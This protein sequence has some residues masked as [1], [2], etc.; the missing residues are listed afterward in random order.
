MRETAG[1]GGQRETLRPEGTG[2]GQEEP[3]FR[4]GG[5]LH[6]RQPSVFLGCPL[7]HTC[8][9]FPLDHPLIMQLESVR[10]DSVRL[11]S[12][13]S[14][15]HVLV[16]QHAERHEREAREHYTAVKRLEDTIAELSYWKHAAAEK[17]A[18]ADKENAG[19]RKRCQELAKL[20][21]RLASGERVGA[22]DVRHCGGGR[23]IAC[24]GPILAYT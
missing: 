21:D 3:G 18:S 1:V 2:K 5:G 12:E 17:L 14:Q 8:R 11:Q 13:N 15:L 7:Y 23:S 6:V 24:D 4:K 22:V 20:T 16:M 19:L 10:Q 9:T